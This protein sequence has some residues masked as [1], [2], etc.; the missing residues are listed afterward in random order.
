VSGSGR[1][2][3]I[4]SVIALAVVT[5]KNVCEERLHSP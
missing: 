2:S 3:I 4:Y 5:T 1:S